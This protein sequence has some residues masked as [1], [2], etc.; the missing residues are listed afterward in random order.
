MGVDPVGE[1]GGSLT[2]DSVGKMNFQGMVC[3]RFCRRVSL[4]IVA[5]LG[6]LGRG[7]LAGTF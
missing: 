7:S 1:R 6:N 3:R 5:P 2:G 4:S